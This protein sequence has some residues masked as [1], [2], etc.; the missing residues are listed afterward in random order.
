MKETEHSTV[1]GHRDTRSETGTI[2]ERNEKDGLPQT[3]ASRK[4]IQQEAKYPQY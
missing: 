4:I 3:P 2:K 1:A